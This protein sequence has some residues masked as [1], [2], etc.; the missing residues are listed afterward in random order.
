MMKRLRRAVDPPDSSRRHLPPTSLTGVTLP[1]I[2]NVQLVHGGSPKPTFYVFRN[3]GGPK[4]LS[5]AAG[6]PKVGR[7]E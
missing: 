1:P 5:A 2:K 6:A 7:K 4:L 3:I